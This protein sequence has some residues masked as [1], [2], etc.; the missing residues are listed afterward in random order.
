M[1]IAFD[2]HRGLV[3]VAAKY[4]VVGRHLIVKDETIVSSQFGRVLRPPVIVEVARR[5]AD[6][7]PEGTDSSRDEIRVVEPCTARVY[8]EIESALEQR[9]FERIERSQRT[10]RSSLERSEKRMRFEARGWQ[11]NSAKQMRL[12]KTI[13][14][15][16]LSENNKRLQKMFVTRQEFG[17]FIANINHKIDS[18]YETLSDRKTGADKI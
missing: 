15:R 4:P 1:K 2:V 14:I 3:F 16:T 10:V 13:T 12:M 8:S 6:R 18:I 5:R 7:Q 17:S 9:N 11:K